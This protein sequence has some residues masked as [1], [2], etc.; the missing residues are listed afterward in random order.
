MGA[1]HAH[2]I[3]AAVTFVI[4]TAVGAP[5]RLMPERVVMGSTAE[6]GPGPA[7]FA[8]TTVRSYPVT[9]CNPPIVKSVAPLV[10]PAE[11][12]AGAP[13]TR[14]WIVYVDTAPPEVG[15]VQDRLTPDA[16]REDAVRPETDPGAVVAALPRLREAKTIVPP[17]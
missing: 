1:V 13:V 9:G 2:V 14:Y 12:Q 16:V 10:C 5:G 15:A 11:I 3:P 7:L 4:C 8:G 6:T 17:E